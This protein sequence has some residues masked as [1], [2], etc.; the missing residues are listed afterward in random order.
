MNISDK[1]LFENNVSLLLWNLDKSVKFMNLLGA[2]VY[3]GKGKKLNIFERKKYLKALNS[4]RNQIRTCFLCLWGL[5]KYMMNNTNIS[6]YSDN[7]NNDTMYT[8]LYIL[9]GYRTWKIKE[10][11]NKELEEWNTFRKRDY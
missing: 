5:D 8:M 1:W 11:N 6:L 7:L 9:Y 10:Y 4:Y 3:E 2:K